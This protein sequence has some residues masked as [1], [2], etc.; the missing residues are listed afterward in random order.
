M[1]CCFVTEVVFLRVFIARSQTILVILV[2]RSLNGILG[3]ISGNWQGCKKNSVHAN[4][5]VN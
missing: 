4:R 3:V 1:H 5:A 2:A